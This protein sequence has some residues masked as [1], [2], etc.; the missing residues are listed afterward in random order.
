MVVGS[1]LHKNL[2]PISTDHEGCSNIK[3]HK[4]TY[5][6]TGWVAISVL[7]K[8]DCPSFHT[9]VRDILIVDHKSIDRSIA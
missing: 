8:P 6:P 5:L 9:C 7:L 1:F 3:I 2:L 4:W